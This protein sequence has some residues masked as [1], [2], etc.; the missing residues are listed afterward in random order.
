[1]FRYGLLKRALQ[2]LGTDKPTDEAQGIEHLGYSPKLVLSDRNNLKVTFPEDLEMA[3]MIL[4][5]RGVA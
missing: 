4:R 5:A 1:M 2:A 3:N